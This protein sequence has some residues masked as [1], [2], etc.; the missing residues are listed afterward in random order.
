MDHHSGSFTTLAPIFFVKSFLYFN[1]TYFLLN[2]LYYLVIFFSVLTILFVSVIFR[3]QFSFNISYYCV[4]WFLLKDSLLFL[5]SFLHILLIMDVN[6]CPSCG[7]CF[8]NLKSHLIR[9]RE[10]SHFFNKKST[11]KQATVMP[12]IDVDQNRPASGA[13]VNQLGNR[14]NSSDHSNCPRYERYDNFDNTNSDD[15]CFE[16]GGDEILHDTISQS[17]SKLTVNQISGDVSGFHLNSITSIPNHYYAMIRLVTCLRATRA[18]KYLLD[19]LIEII[20]DEVSSGRTTLDRL[21]KIDTFLNSLRKYHKARYP[22]PYQIRMLGSVDDIKN[23]RFPMSPIIPVFPFLNNLQSLFNDSDLF[24]NISNLSINASHRWCSQLTSLAS[25]KDMPL[26]MHEGNWRRSYN[27]SFLPANWFDLFGDN[28][29]RVDYCL[30][31]DK[32]GVDAYSRHGL[33]PI[34]FSLTLFTETVRNKAD[35]WRHLTFVPSLSTDSAARQRKIGATMATRHHP[36]ANYHMMLLIAFRELVELQ[37]SPRECN[38]QLGDEWATVPVLIQLNCFLGDAKSNDTLCCRIQSKK[39]SNR[40]CRGCLVSFENSDN[41]LHVCRWIDQ[42]E[43]EMLSLSAIGPSEY[44]RQFHANFDSEL[45]SGMSLWEQFLSYKS[46]HRRYESNLRCRQL[47]AKDMLGVLF[48]CHPVDNAFFHL[49]LGKNPRGITGVT[50]TDCMHAVESGIIPYILKV[51][52]DPLSDTDKRALDSLVNTLFT[53][54]N[55]RCRGMYRFP[56]TNFINGFCSL[57]NLT[58]SDKV[59]RLFTLCYIGRFKKGRDILNNR[60]QEDFDKKRREVS[61]RFQGLSTDNND[62][63]CSDEFDLEDSEEDSE[64]NMHIEFDDKLYCGSEDQNNHIH[65]CLKN[66]GLGYTLSIISSFSKRRRLQI[67]GKIWNRCYVS[68]N[69]STDTSF[70]TYKI[71][72]AKWSSIDSDTSFSGCADLR[73]NILSYIEDKD[74]YTGATFDSNDICS[75][76]S[77]DTNKSSD[78]KESAG[79]LMNCDSSD[80]SVTEDEISHER[81]LRHRDIDSLLRLMEHIVAFRSFYMNWKTSFH[82]ANIPAIA[83]CE[84]NVRRMIRKIVKYISREENTNGWKI[85]KLHDL[86]HVF[87]DTH[88]FGPTSGID[89]SIGERGLKTW[90]KAPSSNTQKNS[91]DIHLE[92]VSQK[93]VDNQI[94]REMSQTMGINDYLEASK[95]LKRPSTGTPTEESRLCVPIFRV[96][97]LPNMDG[98]GTYRVNST[99]SQ[100]FDQSLILHNSILTYLQDNKAMLNIDNEGIIIYSEMHIGQEIFRAHPDYR[101]QGSWYDWG[102]VEYESSSNHSEEVPVKILGFIYND[103]DHKNPFVLSHPCK[104][105]SDKEKKDSWG[106]F[107]HWTLDHLSRTGYGHTKGYKNKRKL[108]WE[109]PSYDLI[110]KDTLLHHCYAVEGDSNL[111][112]KRY[113]NGPVEDGY[114]SYEED[115]SVIVVKDQYEVWPKYFLFQ[116]LQEERI[117]K[118]RNRYKN[119]LNCNSQ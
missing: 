77:S 111:Y 34:V 20:Q 29:F 46:N 54:E 44:Y 22:L 38:I 102:Y 13:N 110:T 108:T 8:P 47:I 43:T 100:H 55:N 48:G 99:L 106:L 105:Q 23:D 104:F 27:D 71:P 56:K 42:A 59:G 103:A 18:P 41:H 94:L 31:T 84:I 75:I 89:A 107:E 9:S 90:A 11:D 79:S 97:V 86:L 50:P 32:T 30:Y 66:L 64:E 115:F 117:E 116:D 21:S 68:Y 70:S 39:E 17:E 85:S 62:L 40:L 60:L 35:S 14:F 76:W 74:A 118:S 49:N 98:L 113:T 5:S 36:L 119:H 53:R 72:E 1:N 81:S 96:Y 16:D 10:C 73:T 67:L 87:V 51:I 25:S 61:N 92:Q 114:L 6:F 83:D 101:S 2:I 63:V 69:R 93:I 57:S 15:I 37:K 4:R 24:S 95:N 78:T 45:Y 88:H 28:F 33:E 112:D 7:K 26:S 109:S 80:D 82:E 19:S 52:L 91:Q 3:F 12:R 58:S 65:A